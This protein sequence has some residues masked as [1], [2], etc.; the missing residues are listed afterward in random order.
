MKKEIRVQITARVKVSLLEQSK[1]QGI[2]ISDFLNE[3]LEKRLEG[4][5]D[6]EEV[7]AEGMLKC[8]M[9]GFQRDVKEI[10]YYAGTCKRCFGTR[11]TV[12]KNSFKM[13]DKSS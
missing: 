3:A 11:E 8:S 4:L 13:K 5:E 1:E 9:C 7:I 2:N 12:P 10:K 6:D